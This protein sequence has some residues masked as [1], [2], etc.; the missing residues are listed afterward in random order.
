MDGTPFAD[1]RN[2]LA[3]S[4][5]LAH[6]R[7]CLLGLDQRNRI[8]YSALSTGVDRGWLDDAVATTGA[9]RASLGPLA[10]LMLPSTGTPI[11]L[12]VRAISLQAGTSLCRAGRR[13]EAREQGQRRNDRLRS[14]RTGAVRRRGM[15][16]VARG[17]RGIRQFFSDPPT[18]GD[19]WLTGN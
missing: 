14:G 18:A 16:R 1:R 3:P 6:T 5:F 4:R 13:G 17:S 8:A 10:R 7:K 11:R 12:R 15:P 19:Y 2:P 9:A